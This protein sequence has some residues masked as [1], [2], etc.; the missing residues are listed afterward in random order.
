MVIFHS[1]VS[2]PEGICCSTE[3]WIVFKH[4]GLVPEKKTSDLRR[5]GLKPLSEATFLAH[6]F[7]V[8]HTC[9]S[10]FTRVFFGFYSQAWG[11]EVH[12]LCK[13]V[14]QKC[15]QTSLQ[16][17]TERLILSYSSKRSEN[18]LSH[19]LTCVRVMSI[20]TQISGTCIAKLS[21]NFYVQVPE[22]QVRTS[23]MKY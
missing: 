14:Q 8:I 10:S 19:H 22:K 11:I 23:L 6:V 2:L 7:W 15:T 1:Y 20:F 9:P 13:L 16:R 4:G 21:S 3:E 18:W 17:D 12:F 5:P